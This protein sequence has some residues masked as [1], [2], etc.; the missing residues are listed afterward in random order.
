[1]KFSIVVLGVLFCL[2]APIQ[3][4]TSPSAK[5][6][7]VA[8]NRTQQPAQPQPPQQPPAA[9]AQQPLTLTGC[10]DERNGHYVLRDEQSGQLL[11]LQAPGSN[12][13]SWFAKYLGHKAQVS[14]AKSSD[15]L[16][17]TGVK[18]VA[19]MC[20]PGTNGTF[21]PGGK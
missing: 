3:A 12:D 7:Q 6:T 13:D 4:Q 16:S 11:S 14:G 2:G 18:Q 5:T 19:D 17:V 10:V 21:S 20:G 15:T 8:A 9:Q 1:M